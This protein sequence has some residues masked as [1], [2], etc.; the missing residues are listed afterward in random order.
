MDL[1]GEATRSPPGHTA[2]DNIAAPPKATPAKVTYTASSPRVAATTA[3]PPSSVQDRGQS[4]AGP[5]SWLS[6]PGFGVN[7]IL[8]V[9]PPEDLNSLKALHREMVNYVAKVKFL[10]L[11]F[12]FYYFIFTCYFHFILHYLLAIL[13]TM[14]IMATSIRRFKTSEKVKVKLQCRLAKANQEL[15]VLRDSTAAEIKA[16]REKLL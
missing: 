2:G 16:L 4:L 12:V 7:Y 3:R 6:K 8:G 10:S 13:Q 15:G 1:E 9:V 5:S 14:A 11:I